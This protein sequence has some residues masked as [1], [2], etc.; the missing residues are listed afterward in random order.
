MVVVGVNLKNKK[1]KPK[2]TD[3]DHSLYIKLW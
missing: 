3:E 2:K 1:K